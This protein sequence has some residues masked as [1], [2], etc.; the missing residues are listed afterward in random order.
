MKVYHVTSLENKDSI[1]KNGIESTLTNR[2][3]NE[4]KR[5]EMEGVYFFTSIDLVY[6]YMS[7][8]VD[9]CEYAIFSCNIDKELLIDD[10]E[11]NKGEA[12]F[13][14]CEFF[15]YDVELVEVC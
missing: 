12:V 8:L 10:P 5:L 7:D 9:D 15:L 1:L 2:F 4:K 6:R 14:A 3:S 11:Y 13:Y